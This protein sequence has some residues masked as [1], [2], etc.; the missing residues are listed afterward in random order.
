MKL[1]A[2]NAE[3]RYQSAFGLQSNLAHCLAHLD[4]LEDFTLTLAQ[5]DFWGEL[6]IPQ[7]LYGREQEIQTLLVAFER[8]SQ[9]ATELV[10]VAGYSGVGKS[11]L[12]HEVHK[13]IT[14]KAG[15]FI[16]G[17]F[18]QY[19]RNIPYSALTSAFN[20]F[21]HELL[22]ES[23]TQLAQWKGRI[24]KAVGS[25][26]Q[27][28]IDVIP[29]L[30]QIIGPQPPVEQVVPLDSATLHPGYT[31]LLWLYLDSNQLSGTIPSALGNLNHLYDLF[32]FQTQRLTSPRAR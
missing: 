10:L 23:E 2:K 18:D 28:L 22:T 30:E 31:S 26:G 11:S 20:K 1:M 15:Y 19:Q 9:G 8:V 6:N 27:I 5:A 24:L 21:C 7:K 29:S 4:C 16:P 3:D 32:L 14:A 13:P 17:K 25:K 12:V